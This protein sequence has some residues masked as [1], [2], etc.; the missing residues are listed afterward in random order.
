MNKLKFK[1][2]QAPS[3]GNSLSVN[4]RPRKRYIIW[5]WLKEF[6]RAIIK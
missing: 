6:V 4:I 2:S 1:V 5:L 3:I